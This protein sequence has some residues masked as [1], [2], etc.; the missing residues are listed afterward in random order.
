V[1]SDAHSQHALEGTPNPA[2]SLTS[3][4]VAV[5][6]VSIS[7][8][9]ATDSCSMTSTQN[10]PS[11]SRT[12][13]LR[14]ASYTSTSDEELHVSLSANSQRLRRREDATS[15][16]MSHS[17]TPLAPQVSLSD[18]TCKPLPRPMLLERYY[19]SGIEF[20]TCIV[21]RATTLI[22]RIFEQYLD[23]VRISVTSS[24]A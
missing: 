23:T 7:G 21:P 16:Q 12:S 3:T 2:N 8:S 4:F 10:A 19:R 17:L 11:L 24:S 22:N 5:N 14:I 6:R 13:A 1:L 18:P 15:A 20:L 9:S